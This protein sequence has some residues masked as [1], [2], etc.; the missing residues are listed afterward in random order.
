[1]NLAPLSELL[2]PKTFSEVVGQKH[3]LDQNGLINKSL[4]SKKPISLLLWGPPGCG[5]TS[6]ARLYCQ[7]FNN[8]PCY[9]ISPMSHGISEIKKLIENQKSNPLFIKQSIVFV[10]EIHRFNK[11]QQDVFLPYVENGRIILI[12]ATTENPS[13]SLNSALLSRLRVL[14]LKPL[15]NEDLSL[16]IRKFCHAYGVSIEHKAL[17][18]L[19]QL[20]SGDA[21]HLINLLENIKTCGIKNLTFEQLSKLSQ[22]KLPNYDKA[23]DNHYN[24]I[25][26]LHKSIRGSDPQSALYWLCR[27]LIAGE[28]PNFI[29]RRLVRMSQEDIGLADPSALHY[30]LNAWEAYKALGSPEGELALAQ[31]VIY[32]ALAPKSNKVYLAFKKALGAAKNTAQESPPLHILNSPTKLMNDLGYGK[33]YQYDHDTK[34]AFSGQNYLPDS[35]EREEFY[36]PVSRGFEREMSKR[37]QYFDSLRKQLNEE[38]LSTRS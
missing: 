29:A 38:K 25:S 8:L 1:M 37:M 24:L 33:G 27:M 30:T 15:K 22:K 23:G 36:S 12:G 18:A 32:L 14:P 26:A 16:I 5:K 4:E 7:A 2:R 34:H 35:L 17:T 6:I 31:A 28:D 13:F 9:N 10:D 3:L 20:S 21:R 11:S 19:M